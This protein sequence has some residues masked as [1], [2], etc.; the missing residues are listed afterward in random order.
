M[1]Y[2]LDTHVFLWFFWDSKNLSDYASSII[3]NDEIEKYISIASMWEF[4]IKYSMG[5]LTFDGGLACLWD[6]LLQNGF[7]ILPINQL[8]LE[9]L[10]TELPFH[11]R[12]PFD[13]LII[14]TAKANDLIIITAD[15]NI[16][17]YDVPWVW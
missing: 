9:I 15:E 16:Q 13:R 14:A 12:D 17:K 10:I 4:S 8:Q 1:K 7:N 5:K 6:M 11:H 3:E 2:L